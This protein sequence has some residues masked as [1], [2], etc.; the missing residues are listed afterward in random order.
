MPRPPHR[1]LI[2][3]DDPDVRLHLGAVLRE[4]GFQVSEV[5]AGTEVVGLLARD[6]HDLVL[7]DIVM[8]GIS[9][10]E[11]LRRLK[12]SMLTSRIP[13]VMLTAL[14]ESHTRDGCK[15]LGAAGFLPKP[16]RESELLRMILK[17]LLDWTDLP[18]EPGA[19]P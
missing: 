15:E 7:L 13:V 16:I 10:I 1:I 18:A 6:R 2:C 14:D 8:P 5:V 4:L 3:D 9:G 11:T 12:N 19:A 17:V